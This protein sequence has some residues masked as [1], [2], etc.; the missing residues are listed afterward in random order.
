MCG[1]CENTF[2]SY[3]TLKA[4]LNTKTCATE[5]GS[6]YQFLVKIGKNPR[7]CESCGEV[8]LRATFKCK[9]RNNEEGLNTQISPQL[10]QPQ[11]VRRGRQQWRSQNRTQW[12]RD[13][14]QHH[15]NRRQC[16]ESQQ[17]RRRPRY[18]APT[19]VQ[20][21]F[22]RNMADDA[23]EHDARLEQLDII[24]LYFANIEAIQYPRKNQRI[25]ELASH[26][27]RRYS[28][29]NTESRIHAA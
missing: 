26:C 28:S 19:N 10:P 25:D 3:S 16:Q 1:K 5:W 21:F 20:P 22:T 27:G 4:H 24:T 18:Q 6:I 7:Q 2:S 12:N 9:C 17:S 14:N 23:E 11:R 15:N 13:H 8:S 29:S